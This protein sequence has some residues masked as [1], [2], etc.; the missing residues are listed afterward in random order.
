[1]SYVPGP[2]PGLSYAA[3]YDPYIYPQPYFAYGYS[4]PPAYQPARYPDYIEPSPIYPEYD[5]SP[6]QEG[7]WDRQPLQDYG[8][9]PFVIN[10]SDAAEHNRNFRTAL[11][12]GKYFQ[13]TLMSIPVGEDIGLEV[14]P[15]TD[16]FVRV[17]E[18]RGV[19]QMGDRADHLTFV[20]NIREDDAVFIPA[21]TW[22]NIINTGNEPLKVYVIYAPP[23]H[24]FG[25]VHRTKR[26]AMMEHE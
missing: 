23:H 10:I 17:E 9:Q 21:G 5:S 1:M 18:G 25:T 3:P 4:N 24:P 19:A 6:L 8:Q 11:W 7:S 2:Y 12:T 16:Q 26:E 20:R 15:D 22:H 14:H 13:V